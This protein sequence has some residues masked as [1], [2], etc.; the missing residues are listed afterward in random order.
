MRNHS[1]ARSS[2]VLLILIVATTVATADVWSQTDSQR[3]ATHLY[4]FTNHG[5]APCRQVEP[6]IQALA[7]EGYPVSTIYVNQQP[8]FAQR[9][10]VNR[11]PTVIMVANN[12][13]VGRHAGLIDGVTLKQWFAAVGVNSGTAFK[14]AE[15]GTKVEL[16]STS[17]TPTSRAWVENATEPAASAQRS[18]FSETN[19]MN[20]TRSLSGVQPFNGSATMHQ[21]TDQPTNA[22]E[23]RA[24]RATVRL[25][26]EDPEGI[27]YATGTVIH[28]H[29]NESLVM[30]CGHVFREAGRKG[31]ITAELGF[32]DGQVISAP[33]Q[34]ISYDA[35][36]RD[37]GL[38]AIRSDVPLEP[39]PV[40]SSMQSISRGQKVFSL[41]CDHGDDPT[42]R[43]TAIK[44][45]AAYDGS[46]KYDIYGRPV[47]G[48]SG[49]GLFNEQGELIG[50]CNAAA[51]EVDE[52]IYTALET[53]HWQI[54]AVN[55]EH[56][57]GIE[58]QTGSVT[59]TPMSMPVSAAESTTAMATNSFSRIERPDA[60]G[61]AMANSMES[62][63]RFAPRQTPVSWGQSRTNND[64]MEVIILV[65]SKSDPS[66][67]QAITVS[68]P[69]P[70]LLDFLGNMPAATASTRQIDVAQ[71][72]KRIA[73]EDLKVR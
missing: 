21:G 30:T 56:L 5:C 64:E 17:A 22:A 38:V 32:A 66:K 46:I 70:Q 29:Q 26:V 69:S 6:G 39:V 24:L 12:K 58:G 63:D 27:S 2:S 20:G 42:I 52:G 72:R 25:K 67:T 73:F 31:E 19:P 65:R 28:S 23:E 35:E 34:L 59:S 10:Q 1:F 18:S 54:A 40:A 8:Q 16:P 68:R 14:D 48:R 62:P 11:T 44:N 61:N 4:F 45:R 41:G 9:F 15:G 53:I 33:G 13:V 55:L 49:G 3:N 43:H 60:L 37:I 47:D 7:R 57:F 71:L 36:A 51:V 50:V